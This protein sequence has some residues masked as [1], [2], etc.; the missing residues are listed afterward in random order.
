MYKSLRALSKKAFIPKIDA[1]TTENEPSKVPG[2]EGSYSEV[3]FVI[4]SS[5]PADITAKESDDSV[6]QVT[7]TVTGPLVGRDAEETIV[8]MMS[9]Y[10][11]IFCTCN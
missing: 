4:R 5:T 6:F 9:I 10:H 11:L 3:T 7:G 1:D 2:K 8:M